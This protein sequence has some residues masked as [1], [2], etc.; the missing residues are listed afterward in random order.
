MEEEEQEIPT[1]EVPLHVALRR[2]RRQLRLSQADVARA[3]EVTP[4]CVT[5]WE[6]GR[7]QMEFWL[8]RLQVRQCVTA[9][10]GG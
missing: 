9:G 1:L 5:L 10:G 3:C 6:A 7:R 4:E 2:R 8:W